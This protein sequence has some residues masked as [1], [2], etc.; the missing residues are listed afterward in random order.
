MGK[1]T[2]E[3]LNNEG[4]VRLACR[5][6]QVR[7]YEYRSAFRDYIR[8]PSKASLGLVKRWE[9]KLKGPITALDDS[10]I[11]KLQRQVYEGKHFDYPYSSK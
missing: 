3:K 4:A 1:L 6:G 7:S 8:N 9:N 2:V 10:D 11:K 5:L